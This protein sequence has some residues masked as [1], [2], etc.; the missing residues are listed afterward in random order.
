[1]KASLGIAKGEMM[2]KVMEDK[3][4]AE[5]HEKLSEIH[6]KLSEIHEKSSEIVLSAVGTTIRFCGAWLLYDIVIV[7]V[8]GAPP[9]T[10]WQALGVWWFIKFI[11][12]FR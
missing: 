11:F 7:P 8:F 5:I 9:V 1:M 10:P 3:E 6:E 4:K 2:D 12:G